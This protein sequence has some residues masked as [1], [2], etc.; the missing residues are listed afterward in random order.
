MKTSLSVS[1][2]HPPR[3]HRAPGGL[4]LGLALLWGA[5]AGAQELM[6]NGNFEAPFPG[7]DP[8]TNWTLVYVDG[9]PADFAIAGQ[10]TEASRAGGGRGAHLRASHWNFSHAYFKQVVRTGITNGGRYLLSIQKM[11]AGFEN[12]DGIPPETGKVRV[13]MTAISGTWST[14]IYGNS[15]SLG[16]YSVIV[17][18]S[19]TRQIEVQLHMA[20]VAMSNESAEDPKHMK[21][22]GWFD[23]I[24]LTWT[25]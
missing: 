19:P 10:T 20:K 15:V 11:K 24:S 25:P 2:P 7:T 16:P 13:Y 8:T 4:L 14:N 18:G 12:Y 5:S 17:T 1:I 6:L 9:G 21:C 3:W 22:T 23:D